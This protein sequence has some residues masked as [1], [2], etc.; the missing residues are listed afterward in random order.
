MRASRA[1]YAQPDYGRIHEELRRKGATLTLLWEEYQ[2]IVRGSH[3]W[4]YCYA[5]DCG[6]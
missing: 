5:R 4:Q 2:R 1:A 3:G 6:G